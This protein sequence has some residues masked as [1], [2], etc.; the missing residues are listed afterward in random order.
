MARD[1]DRLIDARAVHDLEAGSQLEI[2]RRDLR[3]GGGRRGWA[4]R[5]VDLA[6]EGEECAADV[7]VNVEDAKLVFRLARLAHLAGG[8][9]I[10]LTRNVRGPRAQK[11][12]FGSKT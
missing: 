5:R 11:T 7:V 3:R 12:G 2:G 4:G 6:A 9:S 10:S 1:H 8:A